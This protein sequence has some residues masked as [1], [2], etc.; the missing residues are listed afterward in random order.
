[1]IRYTDCIIHSTVKV[2]HCSGSKYFRENQKLSDFEIFIFDT[3]G[4]KI[5]YDALSKVTIKI[6]H[7]T[8]K[9]S[10]YSTYKS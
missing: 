1:M 5:S 4:Y 6:H 3:I 2:G 8:N 10:L 9:S 7:G